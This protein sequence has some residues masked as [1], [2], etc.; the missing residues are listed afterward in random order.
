MLV[1]SAK[2]AESM[3]YRHQGSVSASLLALLLSLGAATGQAADIQ[4][5]LVGGASDGAWVYAALV[6]ADQPDWSH[7]LRTLRSQQDLYFPD[8]PPGDYAVQLFVDRNGN[9]Q[10]DLSPRGIPREPVG[11]SA[12]P[13]LFTGIPAPSKARFTHGAQ[14]SVLP[15][16]LRQAK[17]AA[18]AAARAPL[19][20]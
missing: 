10:L 2:M 8:V 17:R 5:S 6:A 9:G 13:S 16:R 19:T 14:T 12:N 18:E 11:F 7:P 3:P 15:I 1:R 20:R 4:L